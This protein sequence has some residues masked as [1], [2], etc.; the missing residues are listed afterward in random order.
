MLALALPV[1]AEQ[2][3]GVMVG[4]VDMILTGHLLHTDAHIAAMGSLAYLL[5]LLN[6]LFAA[7]AIGATAVVARLV[8]E[9]NDKL[10]AHASNQALL[11]GIVSA[12]PI[13]LLYMFGGETLARWLQ[14]DAAASQLAGRYLFVI[15]LAVPLIAVQRVGIASL[16]GAGDTV[17]GM[18]AM[19]LVNVINLIV[20]VVLATGWGPFPNLGWDGLAIG[21]ALGNG[22]GGL[23]IL[24]CLLAGRARLPLRVDALWPDWPM[25]RR[26]L[27]IGIPGGVDMISILA[28]HLWYLSIINA[29]SLLDAAAHGLGVRIESLAY[30]PGTAFQVA[31]AT[32]AGQALGAAN[33]RRARHGVWLATLVGGALMSAAGL[34]FAFTPQLFALLFLGTTTSDVAQLTIELL[35]IVAVSMPGLAVVMILSGALRGAGDTRV[36]LLVTFAGYLLV[37]IPGAYLL[38]WS[39]IPLP[40]FDIALA[41]W[42]WGATGAWIAMVIDTF[43]RAALVLWRFT[44]GGWTRVEV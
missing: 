27:R 34:L 18:I 4:Y 5:W 11:V 28:C 26:Q 32:I 14:L 44:H 8:G 42:G 23:V 1:L 17:S 30:L 2:L 15:S 10:A 39:E 25:I 22:V 6:S 20:S 12:A 3:L 16:R 13:T 24:S 36:P 35:Q 29:V 40:L 43:V 21:T 19:V 37:R 33:P 31:A 38:A 9:R 7:A 41:G